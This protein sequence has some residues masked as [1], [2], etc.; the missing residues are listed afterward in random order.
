MKRAKRGTIKSIEEHLAYFCVVALKSRRIQELE[1]ELDKLDSIVERY[2]KDILSA[3]DWISYCHYCKEAYPNID[4]Y[5]CEA[6]PFHGVKCCEMCAV[7][8]DHKKRCYDCGVKGCED[9]LVIC[10]HIGCECLICI[11]C[12]KKLDCLHEVCEQHKNPC[13]LC[14]PKKEDDE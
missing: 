5:E 1:E 9:C 2:E 7:L 8:N 3:V 12:S 6:E 14:P 11:R 10:Q 13:I 4:L